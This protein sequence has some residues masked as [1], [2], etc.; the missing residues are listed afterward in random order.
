MTTIVLDCEDEMASY[1]L[2]IRSRSVFFPFVSE[3]L[4][5]VDLIQFQGSRIGPFGIA[6][7]TIVLNCL[8][9][10]SRYEETIHVHRFGPEGV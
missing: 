2:V 6:V 5:L 7:V 10:V 8:I 1:L 9:I 3:S 4:V